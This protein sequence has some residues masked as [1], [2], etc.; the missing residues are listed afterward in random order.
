MLKHKNTSFGRLAV[1]HQGYERAS[2]FKRDELRG[3]RV[4]EKERAGWKKAAPVSE[5]RST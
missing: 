3:E 4:R 1:K 5:R 2:G